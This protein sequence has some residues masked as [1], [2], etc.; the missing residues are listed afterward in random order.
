VNVAICGH[1]LGGALAALLALD[2]GLN[3]PCRSPGAYTYASPR[4]GDHIFAGSF[5]AAILASHRIVNRQDLVPKLPQFCLSLM[6]T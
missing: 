4:T 5:N 1:S 3:T 2:V 6:T